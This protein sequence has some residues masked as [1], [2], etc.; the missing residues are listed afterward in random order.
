MFPW[1]V[2]CDM[3]LRQF[4]DRPTVMHDLQ[5]RVRIGVEDMSLQSAVF[6]FVVES[7]ES[8]VGGI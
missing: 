5:Y 2:S 4:T 3:R 8:L 1:T 7:V 6:S